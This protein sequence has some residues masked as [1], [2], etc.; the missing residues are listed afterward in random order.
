MIVLANEYIE[1]AFVLKGAELQRL[2]R[3]DLD[4]DYLWGGDPAF[5]ARHSPILFPIVG[6]LKQDSYLYEG[7]RYSMPRHGFARDRE[8]RLLEKSPSRLRLE[9]Q[10]DAS[11]LDVYPFSFRLELCYELQGKSLRVQYRVENPASGPLY[12]S[13][14][15]HP[16]FRLPLEPGL[17]FEDYELRFERPETLPRWPLEGNLISGS[18]EPLLQESRR[19]A[20]S[21]GLFDADALV[22]KHPR[23]RWIELASPRGSRSLRMQLEGCPYLGV[24]SA[25]GAPFVCLEPWYGLADGVGHDQQLIHKEGIQRLE[26]G[27]QFVRSYRLEMH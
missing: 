5:W 25:P 10:S 6:G 26:G 9:L 11:T 18:P 27:G 22:F 16:A 12:F 1:A 17:R 24:W 21:H 3:K 2:R 14:G 19:L 23:S 15:G 8:F 20:L 7:I 4:Q 13:I